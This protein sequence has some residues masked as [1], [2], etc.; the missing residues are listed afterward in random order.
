[1]NFFTATES[2]PSGQGTIEQDRCVWRA[3]V[4]AQ[5]QRK[6]EPEHRPY[7]LSIDA[8]SAKGGRLE[9]IAFLFFGVLVSAATLYCGTEL[10]VVNSGALEQTVQALLMR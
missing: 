9:L 1:M 4:T 10:R 6:I 8:A 3:W 5:R 2:F 7:K